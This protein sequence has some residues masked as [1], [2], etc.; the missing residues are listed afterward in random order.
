MDNIDGRDLATII[1][2]VFIP[3]AGV[4]VKRG[5]GGHFFLNLA[6]TF[7][8]FYIPGLVH[9]LYVVLTSDS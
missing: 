2:T 3:P 1:L 8:G 5:F 7:F 4:A 9:G 6:L